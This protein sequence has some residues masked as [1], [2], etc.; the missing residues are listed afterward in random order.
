MKNQT[1][2][3]QIAEIAY[4][5]FSV[6]EESETPEERASLVEAFTETIDRHHTDWVEDVEPILEDLG[7]ETLS[8]NDRETLEKILDALATKFIQ[9]NQ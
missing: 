1:T 8:D 3:T 2:T 9:D 7:I 5:L 4:R 6:Y